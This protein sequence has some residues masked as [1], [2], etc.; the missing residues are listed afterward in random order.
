VVAEDGMLI[1]YIRF[2]L[3]VE[4]WWWQQYAVRLTDVILSKEEQ[5]RTEPAM[6]W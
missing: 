6:L 2:K 5:A 3:F 1:I 4:M